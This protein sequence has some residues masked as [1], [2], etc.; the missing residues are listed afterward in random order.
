MK[1][2]NYV[3]TIL[4]AGLLLGCNQ[5]ENKKSNGVEKV[6]E[7]IQIT[8]TQKELEENK[9]DNSKAQ[10][11]V[12]KAVLNEML[13]TK[14]T[15]EQNKKL[16]ELKKNLEMEFFLEAQAA[17]NVQ[18]KDYEILELYKKNSEK[19]KEGNVVDIFPQL[20]QALYVQKIASGK[21]TVLNEI[22]A[23]YNLNEELKKYQISSEEEKKE[24]DD[25]KSQK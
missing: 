11:L 19:L 6:S 17:K 20:Q 24:T 10:L 7:N 15:E 23:K 21:T 14:L 12:K 3:G 9:D 22:I 4:L 2:K 8:L 13:I 5:E 25:G 18:I 1:V 16:D